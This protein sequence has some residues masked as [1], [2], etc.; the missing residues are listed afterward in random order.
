MKILKTIG[1]RLL[2]TLVAIFL[3]AAMVVIAA[4]GL[5]FVIVGMILAAILAPDDWY[6]GLSIKV[7]PN[8]D[9]DN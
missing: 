4:L 5:P 7:D 3:S 8:L 9:I 2:R 1:K 6:T